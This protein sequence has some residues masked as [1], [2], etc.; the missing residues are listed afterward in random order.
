MVR[1]VEGEV[2][3]SKAEMNSIP[4][5]AD[6]AGDGVLP[7]EIVQTRTATSGTLY[8]QGCPLLVIEL[9]IMSSATRKKACSCT[10]MQACCFQSWPLLT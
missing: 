7:K 2:W 1:Q 3:M 8:Q 4:C 10:C 6:K 9:S 5:G